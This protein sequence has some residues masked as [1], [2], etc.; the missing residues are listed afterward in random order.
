MPTGK[1]E[2]GHL[3]FQLPVCE[4]LAGGRIE[5]GQQVAVQ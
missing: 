3:G 4:G 5:Q 2:G 1:E